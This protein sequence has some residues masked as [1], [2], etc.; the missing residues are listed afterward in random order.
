MKISRGCNEGTYYL[1]FKQTNVQFILWYNF[2]YYFDVVHMCSCAFDIPIW[3]V[4][5]KSFY[6]NLT[7]KI[8]SST[9][10]FSHTYFVCLHEFHTTWRMLNRFPIKFI[11]LAFIQYLDMF[12]FSIFSDRKLHPVFNRFRNSVFFFHTKHIMSCEYIH[13]TLQWK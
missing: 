2:S 8:I 7:H 4:F 3:N 11:T 6:F 12:I 9:V 5:P 13:L 1:L 10:T